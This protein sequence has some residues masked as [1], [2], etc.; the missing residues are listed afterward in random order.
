MKITD[1]DYELPP[2]LIAQTPAPERTGARM[3]V[4][5]RATGKLHLETLVS[6]LPAWLR[7]GDR[8]VVNDTRVI[9][10]RLLGRRAETGG[11]VELLFS[12]PVGPHC[13]AALA[14]PAR[15]LRPGARIRIPGADY[16]LE[17]AT[18]GLGG[19]IEVRVPPDRDWLAELERLGRAPLPPYIHRDLHEPEAPAGRDRYQ[20][21]FAAQPGAVA[22]PTAGLHFTPQ[23]LAQLAASGVPHTTLTLHV[24]L[25]TFRPITAD[26]PREHEMESERYDLSATAVTEIQATRA[27]GGRIVAV[28]TTSTRTLETAARCR[29]GL[30]PGPGRSNLFIYPPFEFRLVDALLTNFHLP[31]STLLMLVAAFA[32]RDLILAAYR[33]AVAARFRFYSY[34]DC[35]LIL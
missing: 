32:G 10:A 20:T 17:V 4:V 14:R 30:A 28:G 15:R 5:E 19:R 16:E 3:L 24:G 2:E 8:L 22:A 31:R 25:G 23:L 18:Q 6:D 12:E 35:M 34:G 11:Q 26:D 9:P 33:Q 27:A 7:A 1:F 21:V 13:W 29:N